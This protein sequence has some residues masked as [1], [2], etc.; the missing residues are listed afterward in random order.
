MKRHDLIAQLEQAGCY[1]IR[2]GG[3]HDIYHNPDTGKTEPIP[4]HREINERLAKKIIKSLT[5]DR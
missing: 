1:L 3:K 4:R 5:G 2:H